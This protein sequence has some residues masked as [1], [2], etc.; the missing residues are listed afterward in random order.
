MENI[1]GTKNL[2]FLLLLFAVMIVRLKGEDAND[3]VDQR[4]NPND[5]SSTDTEA[6][7]TEKGKRTRDEVVVGYH[8]RINNGGGGGI[9][10]GWGGGGGGATQ[11]GGWGWGNGG[12][13][14]VYWRW[15]RGTG[16]RTW[17]KKR[18]MPNHEKGFKIG[19]FAQCMVRGRCKGMRLDCPLHCGGSCFYDC[20][21]M[22]KAHC[23]G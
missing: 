17:H 5:A 22:C 7:N 6:N 19:E 3:G 12:G 21:Y 20:R 2:C 11:R 13:G 10:W 9:G 18:S 8:K 14:G 4:R 15:G 16:K 23:K 1:L